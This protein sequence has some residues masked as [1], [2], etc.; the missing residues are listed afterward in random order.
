MIK[1]DQEIFNI[2]L[3]AISEAVIIV[4]EK[5][6]IME[7]NGM[8]EHIFGYK[9]SELKGKSINILIPSNYHK[10]HKKNVDQ[11]MEDYKR[12]KMG[13]TADVYGLKKIGDIIPIEVELNPFNIYNKTFVMALIRDISKQK[14]SEFN[15]M[16]R[17]KALD[18]ANNGIVITDALKPDNPIIYHNAA[19]ERLTGFT[20]K[21]ILNKNCRFLQGDDRDQKE[22]SKIR[23]AVKNGE[24]CLATLRNYKKDGTI[25]YNDLYITPITNRRG[26]VTHFIGVQ[27]DVTER[28]RAQEE[29]NHLATIFNESLN[30]I[31]VFDAKTLKFINANRGALKNI[32][33]S[34][35]ELTSMT[36]LD[37][38]ANIDL[39]TFRENYINK[40]LKKQEEQVDFETIHIRKDGSS[41]PVMV[42][43]QLSLLKDKKV[44]VAIIVDITEQKNYTIK[45]EQTVQER[46]LQLQEALSKEK[47][48][49][50]LK[51]KFLSLVSHEFKTPLSG[52]ATS[53]MLLEKYRL[54]EEQ[55]KR[56]KHLAILKDKVNYLNTILNDFLSIERLETGTFNYT[57]TDFR[58]SKVINE[59]VYNCN[60]LLKEGQRINYPKD[61]DN[62]AMYQD[63]RIIEIILSNILQ[64]AIK[65]S[66]KNS[67]IDI[68]IHQDKND[69]FFEIEDH[70]IG[71][72]KKEVENIFTRYYRAENVLNLQGTG[73]GLNIVKTHLENLNGT[74]KIE[75]KE[76]KGT[77]VTLKIPNKAKHD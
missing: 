27:N 15:F 66:G 5:Q 18:S 73:I 31:Y 39:E 37:L 51:T 26:V 55:P 1:Q 38:K 41:Y 75:S 7:A 65:Y 44:F 8:A 34:L 42:H 69:T 11:F 12:T 30:E 46:T 21:E 54:T 61:I 56:D 13:R 9:K 49:N 60:M 45:L 14:E 28:V 10:S 29:K 25:F 52:I 16:L 24:S 64:N 40:L 19:F 22:I 77:L 50:E 17:T 70:G 76:N 72:P 62:I 32:G 71:I 2:L 53:L 3:E 74:I 67:T 6:H 68:R 36:P 4:D 23:K 20:K 58:L 48:L 59:V 35:D 63:E 57:F 43:L 33:Y 47:E